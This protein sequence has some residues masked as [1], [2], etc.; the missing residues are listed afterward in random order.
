MAGDRG[1]AG[2]A[3][4]PGAG[5]AA[6]AG[7]N[8][9]SSSAAS[10]SSSCSGGG[11]ERGRKK[12]TGP[13]HNPRYKAKMCKNWV[14]EGKCPYS[15]KCQFAHGVSE[16]EKWNEIRRRQ[17]EGRLKGRPVA[18]AREPERRQPQGE[19]RHLNFEEAEAEADAERCRRREHRLQQPPPQKKSLAPFPHKATRDT[20][21]RRLPDRACWAERSNLRVSTS[22]DIPAHFERDRLSPRYI[23]ASISEESVLDGALGG[24]PLSSAGSVSSSSSSVPSFGS[25]LSSTSS[26]SIYG[27]ASVCRT[28]STLSLR[29]STDSAIYLSMDRPSRRHSSVSSASSVELL[30]CNCVANCVHCLSLDD[31][32]SMDEAEHRE[33]TDDGEAHRLVSELLGTDMPSSSSSF[34]SSSSSLWPQAPFQQSHRY[35]M[36]TSAYDGPVLRSSSPQTADLRTE[37][38]AS[39][40]HEA[41]EYLRAQNPAVSTTPPPILS[42]LQ[43]Q[44]RRS[45]LREHSRQ[46]QEHQERIRAQQNLA[47][48]P[49]SSVMQEGCF[50]TR[51]LGLEPGSGSSPWAD[52]VDTFPTMLSANAQPFA[53]GSQ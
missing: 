4:G 49:M 53:F 25:F 40:S 11:G 20:A 39:W 10:A 22:P 47:S 6:D 23:G 16:L 35:A 34:S 51:Q 26:S 28:D 15:E 7:R 36:Q 14:R 38:E 32:P 45:Q 33:D 18:Q 24:H 48:S 44:E 1:R 12:T 9:S 17:S 5:E 13:I 50:G 27:A 19:E 2:R 46:N 3:G 43:Q 52:G 41:S 21:Y 42:L 37:T 8:S 30:T 29:S 31:A